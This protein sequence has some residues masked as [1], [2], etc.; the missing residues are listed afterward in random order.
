M[1]TCAV[2]LLVLCHLAVS[3]AWTCGE[4]PMLYNAQQIEAGQGKVV[5]RDRS[6]YPYF[7]IGSSWIRLSYVR[8][9]QI[10]VGPAGLWGCDTSSRVYKYVAGNF[11]RSYGLSMSQLDA[12]GDD[13][14][15]GVTTRSRAYCLRASTALTHRGLT[16]LSWSYLSRTFRH[17]SCSPQNGCWGVDTSYRVYHTRTMSSNCV[18]ASWTLVTG[19]RMKL[20]DVGTDGTVIG[21]T[22]AGQVYQRVGTSTSRPAGYGWS[23]ITMC[24]GIRDLSYDLGQL[25][26]VTNAGFIL[27]CRG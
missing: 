20:V 15:V 18:A 10:T 16:S 26:V 19:P 13:Q 23:S 3:H 14:L 27:K 6:N 25:W 24:M 8:F 12:G 17:I 21:L 9:R 1:K 2:F 5:A 7:L 22:T 11:Q 4:A